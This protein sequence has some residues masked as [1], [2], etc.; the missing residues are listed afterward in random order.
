MR[1]SP[2]WPRAEPRRS[3]L[4]DR[5]WRWPRPRHTMVVAG[6]QLPM[7]PLV[8]DAHCAMAK[9]PSGVADID[10]PLSGNITSASIPSRSMSRNRCSG[11]APAADATGPHP[12]ARRCAGGRAV[13]SETRHFTPLASTM[14]RAICSRLG[15]D[16]RGRDRPVVSTRS[17]GGDDHFAGRWYGALRGR[18][19]VTRE[20]LCA[21]HRAVDGQSAA[22]TASLSSGTSAE[23]RRRVVVVGRT[24]LGTG[25]PIRCLAPPTRSPTTRTLPACGLD[26]DHQLRRARA[27]RGRRD[28]TRAPRNKIVPRGATVAHSR[29]KGQGTCGAQIHLI[30]LPDAGM[31]GTAAH[32]SSR[33]RRLSP[34]R[35]VQPVGSAMGGRLAGQS[36]PARSQ[37]V[38]RA[39]EHAPDR[40]TLPR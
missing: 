33:P 34:I 11:S 38:R 37:D 29:S 24:W 40:V 8:V 12:R 25:A 1:G 15:V 39:D 9:A 18:A 27:A 16:P 21:I 36:K 10:S 23:R 5:P 14:T 2:P 17:V 4:R 26:E 6:E 22:P 20:P 31:H 32:G 35:C 3:S 19:G 30:L 28:A 13:A 7:R